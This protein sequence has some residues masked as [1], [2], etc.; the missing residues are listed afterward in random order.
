MSGKF[1]ILWIILSTLYY[2]S[3]SNNILHNN[4]RNFLRVNNLKGK[5]PRVNEDFF[6]KLRTLIH[7]KFNNSKKKKKGTEGKLKKRLFRKFNAATSTR[8]RGEGL[9]LGTDSRPRIDFQE[10]QIAGS[11]EGSDRLY[12]R[13]GEA[14]SREY[15]PVHLQPLRADLRR[16]EGA[17]D[18]R[19]QEARERGGG[20]LWWAELLRPLF[21]PT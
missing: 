15:A 6:I 8:R 1:N 20:F 13:R 18:F 9:T 3:N 5:I 16:G 12:G 17:R 21:D 7:R 14:G 4:E 19:E 11:D 10:S 2:Y